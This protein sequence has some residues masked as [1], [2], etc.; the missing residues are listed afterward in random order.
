[1]AMLELRKYMEYE[2][3]QYFHRK[4]MSKMLFKIMGFTRRMETTCVLNEDGIFRT[5]YKFD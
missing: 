5:D 1:M 2:L 3:G 4:W